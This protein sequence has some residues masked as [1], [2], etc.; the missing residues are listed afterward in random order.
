MIK[1]I[2][3]TLLLVSHVFANNTA[4]DFKQYQALAKSMRNAPQESMKSFKPETV[5]KEYSKNPDA[6]KHYKEGEVDLSSAA[7]EALKNENGA[8]TVIDNYGGT[9]FEINKNSD[10]IKKAL[11]I[12]EESSAIVHG[13]SN[14]RI[15]CDEAKK[16]CKTSY[17]DE[18]CYTS[19][20]LPSQECFA[21]KDI[22]VEREI[23]EKNIEINYG[24]LVKRDKG[25]FVIDLVNGDILGEHPASYTLNPRL[26]LTS[27]CERIDAKF[28][29]FLFNG[30]NKINAAGV[31]MPSCANHGRLTIPNDRF[32]LLTTSFRISIHVRAVLKPQIVQESWQTDCKKIEGMDGFCQLAE[33]ECTQPEQTRVING[34]PVTRTC[35]EKRYRYNCRTEKTDECKSQKAKNCLQIGSFCAKKGEGGCLLYQ[36]SYRCE[37]THCALPVVCTK[38]VFCVD[39]DCITPNPTQN[40][41]FGKSV[42][43]MAVVGEAGRAISEKNN[44]NISLFKGRV[45][46]CR[47]LSRDIGVLDCCADKGW[48]KDAGLFHCRDDEKTL[49][50]ERQSFK[51][52]KLGEYCAEK[53]AGQCVEHKTTYCVFDSKLARIIQ[54]EGRLKQLGSGLLGT[55]ESPI[56]GGISPQELTSIKM[57]KIDFVEPVYPY[58]SG[59]KDKRAGIASDMAV[60][61]PNENSIVTKATKDIQTKMKEGV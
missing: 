56:C 13:A 17:E 1:H 27:A 32:S 52:H 60:T 20:K 16:E 47:R 18:V 34:L 11:L 57:D 26:A 61:T 15:N 39:G 36:Q 53:I 8:R 46:R 55:A 3:L 59:T 41:D 29:I 51:A 21:K 35:W 12:E 2:T 4:T 30:K 38:D 37:K 43:A 23:I 54:E 14:E 28:N 33:E 10:A 22:T 58:G 6:A 44:E 49:S 45:M 50:E 5:F 42:S 9:Q 48:G 7:N 31:D 19:R 40:E 24:A 25:S